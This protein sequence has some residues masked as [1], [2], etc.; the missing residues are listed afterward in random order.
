MPDRYFFHSSFNYL[1]L[2][3]TLT[4]SKRQL[5]KHAQLRATHLP[6]PTYSI[7]FLSIVLISFLYKKKGKNLTYGSIYLPEERK[8]TN[9]GFLYLSRA[10]R[11]QFRYFSSIQERGP[12]SLN[13]I[14]Y[15]HLH[16]ST[17]PTASHLHRSFF[18][19]L[20]LPMLCE[21]PRHI[22]NV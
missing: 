22:F 8:T 10:P 6:T 13:L 12:P 3:L 7:F 15:L 9:C 16:L 2:F 19:L 4:Y 11:H 5:S 1:V 14:F 20:L 18:L 17:T 21:V